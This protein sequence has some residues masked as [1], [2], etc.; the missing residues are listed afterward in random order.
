MNS[1]NFTP[2]GSAYKVSIGKLDIG[3]LVK[4]VDGD[5]YFFPVQN[6]GCWSS[7]VMKEIAAKLDELNKR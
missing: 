4:E 6:D 7:W 3:D 2:I 5:Y 1:L